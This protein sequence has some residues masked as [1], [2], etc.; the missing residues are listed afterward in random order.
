M[1]GGRHRVIFSH[2]DHLRAAAPKDDERDAP[3]EPKRMMLVAYLLV[4]SAVAA[5]TCRVLSLSGGGSFGAFEAGVL[6]RLVE[7]QQA[8]NYDY[9]LGVSAGALN[10]G[11]LSLYPRDAA[12]FASGVASLKDLWI[13]TKSSDVWTYRLDPLKGQPSVLSTAPLEKLLEKV[14]DGRSV[15]RNVTIGTTNLATGAT[16]RHDEDELARNPNVLL[17]A[18]SAIPLVFPPVVVD[19]T[20]HVDGGNSANV[21]TV[22]GIDRCD[23]AANA[24]GMAQPAIHIDVIMAEK[25]IEQLAPEDVANYSLAELATREF[26]IAKKQLFDH[27]LRFQ[28]APGVSSRITSASR[29]AH[30]RLAPSFSLPHAN[31]G[32]DP[33]RRTPHL[34]CCSPR[35]PRALAVTVYAPNSPIEQGALAILNFDMGADVWAVG[36]NTSRVNSTTFNFCL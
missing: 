3:P 22:H 36:Y 32:L 26:E 14:L 29:A 35:F 2:H 13:Q 10:A 11:Y 27:Q 23:L 1:P 7:Q 21:L 9:M 25:T 12:G 24:S 19:G 34:L 33:C 4:S 5:P 18:S 8:L 30:L 31:L 16:A 28:C 20:R 17:R 6:S 15:Q